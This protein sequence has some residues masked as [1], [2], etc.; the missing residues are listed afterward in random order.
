MGYV[1]AE[2]QELFDT[3]EPLTQEEFDSAWDRLDNLAMPKR[4]LGYLMELAA[5]V[6][7]IQ[8]TDHP[9]IPNKEIHLFGADHGVA[10]HSI[11]PT[12]IEVTCQ[13]LINAVHGGTGVASLA[14][15]YDIKVKSINVGIATPIPPNTGVED[16]AVGPGTKDISQEPAM[17][18][19]QAIKAFMAGIDS[20]R[21]GVE[22]RD[23]S[24]VGTGEVG[25]GNT[26]PSTAIICKLTGAAIEDVTGPGSGLDDE[27]IRHKQKVIKRVLDLNADVRNDEYFE[28]M[29]RMG[30]FELC[31][32]AGTV[33][34][35]AIYRIPVVIDGV[36]SAA[37]AMIA[38]G[39][40]PAARE[41]L[42]PS[43][44]SEE[45]GGI[46]AINHLKLRALVDLGM[47]LG[48]GSGAVLGIAIIQGACSMMSNMTT[49]EEAGVSHIMEE[50][51]YESIDEA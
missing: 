16:L 18:E 44:I 41:Y 24:I 31:A 47:R 33:L 29:R 17:T 40:A 25:I 9:A 14:Q 30:G 21:R 32:M 42:F 13:Q 51:E 3:I 2:L 15:A 10:V 37:S 26:T 50:M 20:V 6:S 27:G 48:E 43:H 11:S 46:I 19:E 23:L 38:C 45:P 34:G 5:Q 49:F 28:I 35:A 8:R 1:P 39:M 4:S 22:E 36:L 12:P 7:A